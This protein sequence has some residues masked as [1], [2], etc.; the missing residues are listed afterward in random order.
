MHFIV[1]QF[2]V[3]IALSGLCLGRV[4]SEFHGKS[5]DSPEAG[6]NFGAGRWAPRFGLDI[7]RMRDPAALAFLLAAL[8][9]PVFSVS[10]LATLATASLL[11]RP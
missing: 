7:Q 4:H 11:L 6:P 1:V 5:P 3:V 9:L 10:T 2:K 8:V